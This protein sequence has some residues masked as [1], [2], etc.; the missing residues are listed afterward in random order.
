[1]CVVV[2]V[3]YVVSPTN[4]PAK[5]A[6]P[7]GNPSSILILG[8][9][10]TQNHL[11]TLTFCIVKVKLSYFPLLPIGVLGGSQCPLLA[12]TWQDP[13]QTNWISAQYRNLACYGFHHL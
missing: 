7:A 5:L 13:K 6:V 1:M 3:M 8:N 11:R 10:E 9:C 2:V 12:V 4:L